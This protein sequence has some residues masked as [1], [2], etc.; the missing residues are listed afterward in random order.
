M[1]A[2]YPI[3]ES[4][5]RA[6]HEMVRMSDYIPNSCTDSYRAAVDEAA[7]LV[8]ARKRK[9]SPYCHEKLDAL[10][11]AYSRRL[12][13][14]QLAQRRHTISKNIKTLHIRH[15]CAK[16]LRICSKKFCGF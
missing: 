13:Q 10:L 4:I 6:A 9:V 1:P 15:V 7:A 5:A 14:W 16:A 12:A 11:D 8:D 3:S 2:Y